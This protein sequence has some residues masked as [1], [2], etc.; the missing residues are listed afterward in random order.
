MRMQNAK[1][2]TSCCQPHAEAS[3][4]AVV[5]RRAGYHLTAHCLAMRQLEPVADDETVSA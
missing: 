2:S 3:A 5:V 4:A 1:Q